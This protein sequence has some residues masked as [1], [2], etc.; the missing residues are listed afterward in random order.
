MMNLSSWVNLELKG[1]NEPAG[2]HI[3]RRGAAR[4]RGAGARCGRVRVLVD[5]NTTPT[6]ARQTRG[7]EG[8]QELEA[9]VAGH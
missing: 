6:S 3:A 7:A 2:F 5:T 9:N 8:D 4:A 1:M